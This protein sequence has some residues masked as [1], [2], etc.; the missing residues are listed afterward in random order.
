MNFKLDE[1]DYLTYQLFTASKSELI[2]KKKRNGWIIAPLSFLI[3]AALFYASNNIPLTVYFVFAAVITTVL[4]PRYFN[5]RYK[6]HYKKHI[7]TNYK[8]RFGIES[9]LEI[10]PDGILYKDETGEGKINLKEIKRINNLPAH[11]MIELNIGNSIILPKNQLDEA[12]ILQTF[13]NL[14]LEIIDESN[15]KW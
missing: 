8:N 7:Q 2:T 14:Q 1:E 5:W 13:N 4:F 12:A 6:K 9:E 11:F 3:L 15:W 10:T